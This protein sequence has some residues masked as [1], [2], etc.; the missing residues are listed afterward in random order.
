MC[1]CSHKEEIMED[2]EC[3]LDLWESDPDEPL[4]KIFNV[5]AK[6]GIHRFLRKYEEDLSQFYCLYKSSV[7]HTLEIY[8][9]RAIRMLRLFIS[10]LN[11]K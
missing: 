1:M 7:S 3:L 6:K 4:R 5:R 8:E 11:E 10:N 2:I 9:M